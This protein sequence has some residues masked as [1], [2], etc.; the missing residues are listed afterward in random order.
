MR[1]L[2]KTNRGPGL[3]LVDVA[4]PECGP[5]DVLVE[6]THAAVCGTDLHIFQWDD[7]AAATV[8]PPTT[9]GHEFVGRV[10][11]RGAQVQLVDVG[12]RVVGE[13]HIVCGTCRNCRAGDGHFCRNTIGIGI[14]RD[15]AFAEY[16]SFPAVNAYRVPQF[17]PDEIAAILDPLGNAVH[18]A[19]SF[20]L[21][22]EDV[23]ITGAGPIGQMA[24]AICRHA[25]ARHIVI[26]DPSG[27]RLETARNMGVDV[28]TS[29]GED[30]LRAAMADLGMAEGF[31]VALE[32]SGHQSALA[33]VIS[34]INHGGKVG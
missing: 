33:D 26:T 11:D 5:N 18:T 24:A 22:G 9:I 1:A 10:V 8:V 2:A 4:K 31:D 25:G 13:G 23:L 28:A 3:E 20:D 30:S 27:A 29:P 6:V 17:V 14:N 21:V 32:M 34:T 16:I 12:D 15:G 7:W 19:L